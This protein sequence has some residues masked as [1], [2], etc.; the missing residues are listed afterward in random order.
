MMSGQVEGLIVASTLPEDS[1]D[2]FADL[3][4]VRVPFVLIDRYFRRLSCSRLTTDTSKWG[5]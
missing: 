4:R 1:C 2:Y 3:Q 5:A